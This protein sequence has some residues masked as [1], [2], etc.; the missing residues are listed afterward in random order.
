MPRP[1]RTASD[2]IL[3]AEDLSSIVRHTIGVGERAEQLLTAG[4]HLKRGLLL[5]GPPGTGKTHTIGYLM[6]SMPE[7]T[8]VVLQGPSVGALGYA[9][10]IVR[11][12]TP[13]MLVIED[14]DL[15]ATERGMPGMGPADP[16]LFQLLNEMDGLTA[17]D[18][19]LFVLTTNRVD[20]LEPALVARPGRVDHAV[21]IGPPDEAGRKRLLELY[22][23]E[24][25]DLDGLEAV[26][27]RTE[28]VTASFM[29]E[30]V[31]RATLVAL[32]DTG[33]SV[34]GNGHLESA[35]DELLEGSVPIVR[36]M[37]GAGQHGDDPP[38]SMD[39]SDYER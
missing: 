15:I 28:G 37:L 22:L 17:T 4:R 11:N 5:F 8:T 9:A 3:P 34:V 24:N 16:L 23:N 14:I 25:D 1:E 35:L 27:E 29:K 2:V 33:N 39:T 30:L 31:R 10:A 26:V 36:A 19:V 13:S 7:R 6:A 32:D 21:E 20:V 18:D 38:P 12:L